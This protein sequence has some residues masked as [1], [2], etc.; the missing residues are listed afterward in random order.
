M[1]KIG[2]LKVVIEPWKELESEIQDNL[3]LAELLKEEGKSEGPD[4]ESL[5]EPRTNS[6]NASKRWSFARC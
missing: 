3:D 5:S 6:R 2:A 1:K 4:V